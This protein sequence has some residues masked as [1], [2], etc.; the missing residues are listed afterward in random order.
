M[1]YPV[2]VL[3]G[4]SPLSGSVSVRGGGP[5]G[6][7]V[8]SDNASVKGDKFTFKASATDCRLQVAVTDPELSFKA[9]PAVVTVKSE[10]GGFSFLLRDVYSETP[11]LLPMFGAA[12]VSADDERSYDQVKRTVEGRGLRHA[13]QRIEEEPE[14]DFDTA[15]A[16]CRKLTCPTWLGITRDVRNFEVGWDNV[17][18]TARPKYHSV[19]IPR[20]D[21]GCPET[22]Y[23]IIMGKGIGPVENFK[24]TLDEDVRPILR[25][26]LIDGAVRYDA[27][28]FS[29]LEKSKLKASNVRGTNFFAADGLGYGHMFSPEQQAEFDAMIEGEKHPGEEVVLYIHAEAVNSGRTP[30]YAWFKA[31]FFYWTKLGFDGENGLVMADKKSVCATFSVNGEPAPKSEIAALLQPGET[32]TFDVRILHQPVS[33]ARAKRLSS[34]SFE[35]KLLEARAYWDE[36]TLSHGNVML[37]EPRISSMME[38]GMHHLDMVTY[39]LEPDK[40]VAAC[41]GVYCPIGSESA[42]IIQHFDS[43]GWHDLA[44]RSI[45]YFIDKQH[46]NGFIQNFGNY[47]LETGPALWTMGEHY[48]YTRDLEWVKKIQPNILK[49]CEYLQGWCDRNKDESLKGRGYGMMEGKVG[50]PEDPYHIFMLNSYAYLGLSRVAEMLTEV[51]PSESERIQAQAQELKDNILDSLREAILRSP[52]VPLS[53]GTWVPTV[54]PFAESD[55]MKC[56]LLDNEEWFTHGTI[57]A[58]D[59]IVGPIYLALTEVLDPWDPVVTWILQYSA[60]MFHQRNVAQSQPYYSPHPYVHL[61]RGE[62]KPFLKEFYNCMSGLADRDTYSFWEHF[63]HVSLHKTHEEGWFLMRCRWMLWM[64]DGNTLNLFPGIPRDWM[65]C[66]SH[67]L[68]NEVASYFG[69]LS[70][71]ALYEASDTVGGDELSIDIRCHDEWRAPENIVIRVPHRHGRRASYVSS[72]TYDPQTETVLLEHFTGKAELVIKF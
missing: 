14:E 56:L 17:S 33:V 58:R 65:Q 48:R 49:A 22:V 36:K 4:E 61:K 34:K 16:N 25:S 46:E 29:T 32:I 43:M 44:Q 47:M 51:N 18:L 67:I 6:L 37:P 55:E 11:I 8:C 41:I 64:E 23:S 31:P 1:E 27:T 19:A 35:V 26:E 39:G 42:P 7:S 50:D 12:V 10:K 63:Y 70:V 52:V 5:V 3:W 62:V 45:Q 2:K 68:L 72:G 57:T 21:G 71:H 24:R 30:S 38:A 54:P 59:S 60:D 66:C 20:F 40:T 69:P 9:D 53:D 28:V 13:L 15:A